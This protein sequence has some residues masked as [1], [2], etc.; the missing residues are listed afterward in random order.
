MKQ[1]G[2]LVWKEISWLLLNIV[3]SFLYFVYN[4]EILSPLKRGQS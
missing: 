1:K 3:L 2:E 4:S